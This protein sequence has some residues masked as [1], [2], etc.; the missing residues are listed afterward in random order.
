MV[1]T[2]EHPGRGGFGLAAPRLTVAPPAAGSFVPGG[3]TDSAKRK[4]DTAT[5]VTVPGRTLEIR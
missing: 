2:L 5:V 3:M 4:P 1:A